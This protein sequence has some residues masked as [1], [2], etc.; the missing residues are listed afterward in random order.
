MARSGL[1]R[2]QSTRPLR[3][4]RALLML[5]GASFVIPF[6][7]LFAFLALKI[8][9]GQ[10][11]FAY[12]YSPVRE[13]RTPRAFVGIVIGLIACGAVWI[14][15]RSDRRRIGVALLFSTFC[16]WGAWT[17]WAPPQPMTQ[18]MFSL[19]SP[20]ADGAFVAQAEANISLPAYLRAFD[21]NLK[22]SIAQMN[23]T[24]VLS[25]PPGMTIFA[26][27]VS[28]IPLG[29]ARFERWLIED[30]EIPPDDVKPVS[31]ALRVA[32]ALCAA[33][34]LSGMIAY[35]LGR[36]FLSP[37]G[38]GVFAIAVTFSPCAVA[39]VPGK[40]PAQLLTINA[41][42]WAWFAAWK[43][44]S[45]LLAALAG[46]IFVIGAIFS[47]VHV[48]VALIM[49]AAVIWEDRHLPWRGILAL[50]CG[51]MV[52]AGIVYLAIGWNIPATLLAVSHRWSE[53]QKTFDMSRPTWFAIGLPIFLL[54]LAPGFWALLGLSIRR[55]RLN[56]GT[57]LAICTGAVMLLIYVVVGVT[58][59]LPRLWVAF[60]PPLML[61]L[62]IDRPLLRGSDWIVHRPVAMA[63]V[64]IVFAQIAFTAMHWTFF[65]VRE[66]EYRL[67]SGRF[68]H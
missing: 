36:L 16:L 46:M 62:A 28:E 66:T 55:P 22:L 27:L 31:D 32:M 68:Y 39:F 59:E 12:R 14:L 19:T 42:L 2:T 44:R 47:L 20:S 17:F 65:D 5:L 11:Y 43:R 23:G 4:S 1:R 33:W 8:R 50:A 10:G 38:A 60:L 51:A 24:R 37:A 64:L 54:F 34:A 61:G 25:N 49:V 56:V 58:Y 30:A 45:M 9:L 67:T 52:V 15:A 63:L 13:L 57:R 40:D 53:I 41:M 21:R 26:R 18:Q 3:K 7:I 6:A 35:A 48:W 29:R